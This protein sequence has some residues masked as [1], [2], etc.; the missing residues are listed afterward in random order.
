MGV[1]AWSSVLRTCLCT[2][3]VLKSC[4]SEDVSGLGSTNCS[5]LSSNP[6]RHRKFP[7][8]NLLYYANSCATFQ[9]ELLVCDDIQSN[10]EPEPSE[11]HHHHTV[12][13][14][15]EV[16]SRITYSRYELTKL[17]NSDHFLL[18]PVWATVKA[19]DIARKPPTQRGCRAGRRKQRQLIPVMSHPRNNINE[20]RIIRGRSLSNLVN[21]D[22]NVT[23][24]ATSFCPPSFML[25]NARSLVQRIDELDVMLTSN[26]IEA[27]SNLR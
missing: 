18:V 23:N 17:I 15:H 20:N 2:L 9:H 24:E 14:S 21:I 1:N 11:I 6:S 13:I 19:L 5:E 3:V 16:N 25:M 26:N 4:T 27:V 8:G 12:S 7:G 22:T 10:P